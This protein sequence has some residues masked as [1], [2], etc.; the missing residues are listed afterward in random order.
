M[1]EVLFNIKNELADYVIDNL[2]PLIYNGY[3]SIYEV[4]SETK[5]PCKSWNI[6]L[7]G[8]HQWD[9]NLLNDENERIKNNFKDYDNIINLMI[10]LQLNIY[11]NSCYVDLYDKVQPKVFTHMVYLNTSMKLINGYELFAKNMMGVIFKIIKSQIL[12]T[13]HDITFQYVSIKEIDKNITDYI[14][15][16]RIKFDDTE[17][18]NKKSNS[19]PSIIRKDSVEP[20][21]PSVVNN[22]PMIPPQI[23]DSELKMLSDIPV[24]EPKSKHISEKV[25]EKSSEK[26][27]DKKNIDLVKFYDIFDPL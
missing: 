26:G 4:S 20:E 24:K 16:T 7:D 6:C 5:N 3:N 27:S 10:K 13:I 22:T 17:E 25:T 8:I 21:A 2:F 12:K 14:K 9:D 15:K 23:K 11:N 18:S 1:T 19:S